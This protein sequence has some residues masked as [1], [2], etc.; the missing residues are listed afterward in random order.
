MKLFGFW[1]I[2]EWISSI[3]AFRS[4]K[5]TAGPTSCPW[6]TILVLNLSFHDRSLDMKRSQDFR[7]LN[8]ANLSQNISYPQINSV[9]SINSFSF[10]PWKSL[11]A[12][13]RIYRDSQFK[14]FYFLQTIL[15]FSNTEM[16]NRLLLSDYLSLLLIWDP[17]QISELF[18]KH[19]FYHVNPRA[20]QCV[21]I[22]NSCPYRT[23]I[24]KCHAV[25]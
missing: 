15:R 12:V 4:L 11:K 10:F 2:N 22:I 8:V 19:Y 16:F 7:K 5:Q 25:Y 17:F 1:Q 18:L 14:L 6:K 24:L 20:S 3:H 21:T 9:K 23:C 13:L